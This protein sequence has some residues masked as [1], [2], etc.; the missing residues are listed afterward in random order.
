MRYRPK[1]IC[2]ERTLNYERW[3][4]HSKHLHEA[5]DT[6]NCYTRIFFASFSKGFDIIA[7]N[8]ILQE[9]CFLNVDQTLFV[10]IRALLTDRTQAVRVGSPLSPWL[11]TYGGVPQGTKLGTTLFAIMINGLLGDWHSRLKYVDDMT[12][13]EVIPRNSSSLLDFAVRDIHNC[14]TEHSM[15][16]PCI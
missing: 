7:H 16:D 3:F 15:R 10:W 4:I 1:T 11:H 12:V 5:V 6:G 2:S 9:L 8:I 13:F 14:C